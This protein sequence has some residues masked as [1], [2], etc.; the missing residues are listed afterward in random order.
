MTL[1]CY[2]NPAV[3]MDLKA[4]RFAVIF[5]GYNP[6]SLGGDTKNTPIRHVYTIE[7]SIPIK[8][9]SLKK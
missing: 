4:V 1:I 6:F 7:V 3:L 8:G 9:G 2:K 5:R